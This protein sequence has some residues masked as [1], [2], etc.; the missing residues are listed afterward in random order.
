[1][2]AVVS[3]TWFRRSFSIGHP[4][5]RSKLVNTLR[6][7]GLSL[8]DR[9]VPVLRDVDPAVGAHDVFPRPLRL[10]VRHVSG[11][12]SSPSWLSPKCLAG[13][14]ATVEYMDVLHPP[15]SDAKRSGAEIRRD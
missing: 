5:S 1:M 12:D 15:E 13:G 11:D 7:A 9:E 14:I 6:F 10:Q 4:V 3:C 8:G 2:F